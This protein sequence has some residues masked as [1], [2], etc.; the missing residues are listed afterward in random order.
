MAYGPELDVADHA[1]PPEWSATTGRTTGPARTYPRRKLADKPYKKSTTNDTPQPLDPPLDPQ[2]QP[3][4]QT[5]ARTGVHWSVS[6]HQPQAA[7][8]IS[9]GPHQTLSTTLEN[10]MYTLTAYDMKQDVALYARELFSYSRQM[11]AAKSSDTLFHLAN[12]CEASERRGGIFDFYYM[13]SLMR[14]T[15]KCIR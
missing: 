15:F 11:S 8:E 12:K 5:C 13:V 3:P 10:F 2:Q 14:L 4:P 6:R 1:S 7:W 9:N